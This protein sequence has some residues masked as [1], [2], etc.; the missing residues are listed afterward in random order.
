VCSLSE[1][2]SQ[3]EASILEL[4]ADKDEALLIRRD[5]LLVLNLGPNRLDGIR[6]LDFQDDDGLS[7]QGI[8]KNLHSMHQALCLEVNSTN[9]YLYSNEKRRGRERDKERERK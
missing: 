4:L 2:C 8:D 9:N 5:S 6:A 7:S 3:K 1:H